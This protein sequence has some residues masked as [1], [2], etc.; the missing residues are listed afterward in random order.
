MCR[1]GRILQSIECSPKDAR[2]RQILR[3]LKLLVCAP[4]VVK[5]SEVESWLVI[6]P[7]SR[8]MLERPSIR[9]CGQLLEIMP[10]STIQFVHFSVK[11][12]RV[13]F[14]TFVQHEQLF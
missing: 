14:P 2:Q 11:E 10:D 1:Y 4:R 7:G 13:T 8:K 12:L 9:D 5:V 3:I 6:D